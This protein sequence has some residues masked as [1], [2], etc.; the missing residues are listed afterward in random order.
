VTKK[1][2]SRWTISEA[3]QKRE[4]CAAFKN[5]IFDQHQLAAED[6]G[7]VMKSE[8]EAVSTDQIKVI[9]LWDIIDSL[10]TSLFDS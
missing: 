8:F 1:S 6:K 4:I 5:C 10:N 7:S 9:T 3:E 2:T